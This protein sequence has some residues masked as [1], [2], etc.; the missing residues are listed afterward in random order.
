MPCLTNASKIGSWLLTKEACAALSAVLTSV[1]TTPSRE[2]VE[3]SGNLLISTMVSLKHQGAAFAAHKALQQI[4]A[5]C[6]NRKSEQILRSIPVGWAKRLMSEMSATESVRDSTLRRST[7]YAL[8]CLSIM[9]SELPASVAPRTQCLFMLT[10]ILRYSLPPKTK[11]LGLQKAKIFQ[12]VQ[13]TSLFAFPA[14][15]EAAEWLLPDD[16]YE[17]SHDYLC[18]RQPKLN[19]LLQ[20]RCRVHALNILRLIILDAP[21]AADVGPFVGDAIMSAILGYNDE[22]WAV[23][24]SSTMVFSA[25][26]LRV[27]DA[28]RNGVRRDSSAGNAITVVEFFRLYPSLAG[29]LVGALRHYEADEANASQSSKLLNPSVYPILLLLARLQP[30]KSLDSSRSI[31]NEFTEP[32]ARCLLHG[33]HKVRLMAARAL[34]NLCGGHNDAELSDNDTFVRCFALLQERADWN[35]KHGA[36]Q[37][38]ASIVQSYKGEPSASTLFDSLAPMRRASGKIPPPCTA[39]LVAIEHTRLMHADSSRGD[40]REFFV[41]ECFETLNRLGEGDVSIGVARLRA[42]VARTICEQISPCIWARDDDDSIGHLGFLLMSGSIDVRIESAKAFKK[43]ARSGFQTLAGSSSVPMEKKVAR[44]GQIVNVLRDATVHELHNHASPAFSLPPHEPTL[45]RLTRCLLD[46]LYCMMSLSLDVNSCLGGLWE[47]ANGLIDVGNTE[48]DHDSTIAG[49]AV[50]LMGVAISGQ[51]NY[52]LHDRVQVFTSILKELNDPMASWRIRHSVAMAVKSSQ[53]MTVSSQDIANEK[54]TLYWETLKLLQDSDP[55]V[56]FVAT[57]IISSV[58]TTV[59]SSTTPAFALGACLATSSVSSKGSP[60]AMLG[61]VLE[62]CNKALEEATAF[63][64]EMAASERPTA[65][66]L[67]NLEASRKIFEDENPNPYEEVLVTN[68][69]MVSSLARREKAGPPMC[70][71]VHCSR[72]LS[73][74]KNLLQVVRVRTIES[75][76]RTGQDHADLIHEMTRSSKVFPSLHTLLLASI[77][78]LYWGAQGT[79]GVKIEAKKLLELSDPRTSQ[80][81]HPKIREAVEVLERSQGGD[82]STQ[83]ALLRCCFLA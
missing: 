52:Q 6:N 39:A 46:G 28:D 17:V 64:A 36:L 4:A 41:R 42:V 48:I 78:V 34:A 33:H 12:D 69:L 51:I 82:S 55:D 53:L 11:V 24:N 31:V 67:L 59:S 16:E 22:S 8:G 45:R 76:Q 3:I 30:N 38:I 18:C 1:A 2:Q 10:T 79:E 29:F 14:K 49:N 61:V 7:G 37:A 73:L 35:S 32:V 19:S 66:S 13:L 75:L 83:D 60:E 80:T 25:A 63:Q 21:V 20:S 57:S 77:L 58:S 54:Q 5:L 72:I 62:T 65:E 40:S 81:I 74:C 70:N 68:H 23:R 26:M 47:L 50:E 56:R 9:R 15:L 71:M 44:I 27:V 43:T